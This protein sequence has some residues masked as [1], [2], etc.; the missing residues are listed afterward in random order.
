MLSATDQFDKSHE[1]YE[2][3]LEAID[4]SARDAEARVKLGLDEQIAEFAY[5]YDDL[6]R[7][8]HKASMDAGLQYDQKEQSLEQARITD[9]T[10]KE[11]VST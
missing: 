2:T 4:L 7:D 8:M 10:S 6:E 9:M 3:T 1:T 11:N 5:Q